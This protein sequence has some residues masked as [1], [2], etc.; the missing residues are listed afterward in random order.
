MQI[1]RPSRTYKAGLAVSRF[2]RRKTPGEDR[3]VRFDFQ[4][5]YGDRDRL[6][7]MIV[8]LLRRGPTVR[9]SRAGA[10]IFFEIV[11]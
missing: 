10:I 1:R 8:F 3:D 2:P 5:R 6:A 11:T 7:V 4:D 9:Y